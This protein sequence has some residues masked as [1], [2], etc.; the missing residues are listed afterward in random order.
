M[1]NSDEYNYKEKPVILF[2]ADYNEWFYEVPK[3]TYMKFLAWA[4]YNTLL[5]ERG[6]ELHLW[7]EEGR[8]VELVGFVVK[9]NDGYVYCLSKKLVDK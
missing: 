6:L 2:K 3:A 8:S 4:T 7:G 1:N 5:E 9:E